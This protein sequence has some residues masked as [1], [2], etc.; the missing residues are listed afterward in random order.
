MTD[1]ELIAVL[2]SRF[3]AIAEQLDGRFA[4][5]D[6]RFAQIDGR[7]AQIDDRFERMDGRLENVETGL[8]YANVQIENLRDVTR[9][10]AE[11]VI[12]VDEK[13]ERFR[14]D[15]AREFEEMRSFN[16]LSYRQ[17]EEQSNSFEQRLTNVE[18]RVAAL[19]SKP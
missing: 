1:Q 16:R 13:L 19:E 4:Q 15:T 2:D 7:F 3:G 10:I 8:R 6:G 11:S 14:L 18:T 17:I 9:K 5:I 12:L